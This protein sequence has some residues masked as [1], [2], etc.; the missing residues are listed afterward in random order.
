M[1]KVNSEKSTSHYD[2]NTPFKVVW[3][4]LQFLQDERILKFD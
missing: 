2:K 4:T 3:G 1:K